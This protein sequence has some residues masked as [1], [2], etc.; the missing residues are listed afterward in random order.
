[1]RISARELQS[2][3]SAPRPSACASSMAAR[4][5]R[6]TRSSCSSIDNVDGALVGG[7]S[8]KAADFLGIAEAYR[9]RSEGLA[10]EFAAALLQSSGQTRCRPH[11]DP[12]QRLLAG[13]E[14]PR[15]PCIEPPSIGGRSHARR[16]KSAGKLYGNRPHRHPSDGRA[17]ACRRRAAAA[18]GRRRPRHRRRFRLHDG[19]RRG[20]R[21]DAGDR[22]SWRPRSSSTSLGLSISPATANSRSTSSTACRPPT[23]R[24]AA[25]ACST[26]SAARRRRHAAPAASGDPAPAAG[27]AAAPRR[28]TG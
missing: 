21:A 1:M 7:A 14:M 26:S 18:L 10:M 8:L 12:G 19:A 27:D 28:R 3:C 2:N 13:L 9:A 22:R 4:S 5:S 17:R 16:R 15:K 11:I 6:R 23:A 25:A 20:Q 24:A